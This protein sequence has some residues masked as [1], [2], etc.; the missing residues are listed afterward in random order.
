MW[1]HN[2]QS[3][4][5]LVELAIVMV[6]IGLLLGGVL[7]GQEMIENGKI[8]NV[9]NDVQGMTA[10]YYTY[11]D[12]YN[13]L[14]GDDPKAATRWAGVTGAAPLPPTPMAGN[15]DGI[16]DAKVTW[17]ACTSVATPTV[18][19]CAFIQDLRLAGLITGTQN[20][21]DPLN[22]YGGVIRVI[23]NDNSTNTNTGY[24]VGLNLCF[25]NLPAK[26]AE[27]IDAN[28]DDGN[29]ATG[30]VRAVANANPNTSPVAVAVANYAEAAGTVF[31]TVCRLL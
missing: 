4:F 5:T 27:S 11:R 22:A 19:S 13:A 26:A 14:P 24:A 12:R 3:G 17:T 1:T 6:I 7:K 25:S 30:S 16:V 18:E 28:F 23:Q 15:G 20:G 21:V 2:K 31:Y 9:K 10:A 29:P 8:K